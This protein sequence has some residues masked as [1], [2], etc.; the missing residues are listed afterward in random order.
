MKYGIPIVEEG[1]ISLNPERH[2]FTFGLAARRWRAFASYR[3]TLGISR[4]EHDELVGDEVGTHFD[5]DTRGSRSDAV[6]PARP[7]GSQAP[8]AARS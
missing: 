1:L 5:N 6:A 8:S 2:A 7:V 3:A 4:Y